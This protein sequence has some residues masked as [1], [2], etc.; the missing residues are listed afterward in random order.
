[1]DNNRQHLRYIQERAASGCMISTCLLAATSLLS[2]AD[3]QDYERKFHFGYYGKFG[4]LYVIPDQ[5][6]GTPSSCR[7]AGFGTMTGQIYS[8]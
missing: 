3:Q 1:M 5:W 6:G 4:S 8:L 2:D 7:K